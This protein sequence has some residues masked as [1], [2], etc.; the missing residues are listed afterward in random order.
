MCDCVCTLSTDGNVCA[1]AAAHDVAWLPTCDRCSPSAAALCGSPI[2][3]SGMCIYIYILPLALGNRYCHGLPFT[4]IGYV[5]FLFTYTPN[6]QILYMG[7]DN[8]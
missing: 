2:T 6:E 4:C 5:G 1:S 7:R 8:A 3:Y